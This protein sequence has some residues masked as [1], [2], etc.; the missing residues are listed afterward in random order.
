MGFFGH[1]KVWDWDL[2]THCEKGVEEEEGGDNSSSE[3][4]QILHPYVLLLLY[5][6]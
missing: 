3:K 1:D 6:T 2:H 5:M 4:S